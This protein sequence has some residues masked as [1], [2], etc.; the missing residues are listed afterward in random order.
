MGREVK[1]VPL[2]FD[3]PSGTT[4]TGYLMP[5]ELSLPECLDCAGR[6][7]TSAARWVSAIAHLLLMADDDLRSQAQGRPLHPWLAQLS[8]APGE[9]PSPD[10]AE[11]GTGLAGR[12]GS[13]L[14]HDAIDRWRA[15]A[16]IIKAAGLPQSWG[17]CETC[18]GKGE[19]ATDEQRAA[20]EAWERTEPPA[21][22]GWQLWETVSEG[23]PISPVF[24]TD[25]ELARWMGV[26]DCTVNGP[27]RDFDAALRFVRA[28]WAPSFM[29]SPETGFMSGTDWVARADR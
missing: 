6:G 27:M 4:W 13:F 24:G 5:K 10:I 8:L 19:V 14:G 29:S 20:H 7:D 25:E 11:V 3:H 15:A 21:G 12:S 22:D 18:S 1:R 2:D 28:G 16:A 17:K 26:N 9:R 23:S